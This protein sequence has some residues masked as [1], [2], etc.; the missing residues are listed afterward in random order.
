VVMTIGVNLLTLL[1]H[2]RENAFRKDIDKDH[3]ISDS[4]TTLDTH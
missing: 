4:V 2:I 1:L 3:F